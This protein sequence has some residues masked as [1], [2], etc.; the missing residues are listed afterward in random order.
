MV[1]FSNHS[2]VDTYGYPYKPPY[3]L[4][5]FDDGNKGGRTALLRNMIGDYA[6]FDN[7]GTWE[8]MGTGFT[9]ADE[10]PGAQTD[11]EVYINEVTASASITSYETEFPYESRLIPSQ[12]AIYKLW[13]MGRDHATGEAAEL[14]YVKVDLFNPIGEATDT[15]AEFTA[16]KFRVV[17]QVSSTS[18]NGGEKIAVSG[19]L[20]AMGDPVQGKF[21][22]V[23]KEFTE[24]TFS[25]KYDEAAEAAG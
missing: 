8:L 1:I 16:R 4:N 13:K 6:Q 19:S 20:L 7:D 14:D 21:N 25:G 3:K 15:S 5:I 12:R 24:G 2:F 22:T 11:S 9:K 10:N 23:T 18:G 17:N